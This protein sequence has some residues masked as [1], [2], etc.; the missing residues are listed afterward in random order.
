MKDENEPSMYV[1]EVLTRIPAWYERWGISML[2]ILFVLMLV[3]SWFIHYPDIAHAPIVLTTQDPPLPI[4][5]RSQGLLTRLCRENT[6]VQKGEYLAVIE[7]PASFEEIQAVK[8]QLTQ[9]LQT[10]SLTMARYKPLAVYRMGEIQIEYSAFV[11]SLQNYQRTLRLPF[12]LQR[13]TNADQQFHS[14]ASLQAK[15]KRQLILAEKEFQLAKI[16]Y[17][18]DSLLLAQKVIAAADFEK[19][20]IVFLQKKN[21]LEAIYIMLENS[22]L[23]KTQLMES[24]ITNTERYVATQQQLYATLQEDMRKLMSRLDWWE[25]TY[26]LKA[27]ISGQV[28]FLKNWVPNQFVPANEAIF[29]LV[30][31]QKNIIGTI[32]LPLQYASRVQAGQQVRIKLESYPYYQYGSLAGQI[33]NLSLV[34][35]KDNYLLTVRLLN[36]L[37]TSFNRTL[38]FKQQ[39]QGT[40][41]IITEDFTL[42]ERI[43]LPIRSLLQEP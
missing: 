19:T 10:D 23:T 17:Q 15:Q 22:A 21:A 42:F 14:L 1:T 38:V 27:P 6:Y 18:R 33:E 26:V 3:L 35:T 41:Q 34:P 24:L 28:A 36:G 20:Q 5:S 9:L 7:N 40:A 43:F 30:P 25:Q 12:H 32:Y 37:Q 13:M 8:T 11:Q 4:V 16:T 29:S 2:A 31:S 39:M